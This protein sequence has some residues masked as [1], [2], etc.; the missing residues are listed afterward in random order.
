MRTPA[1]VP[2]STSSVNAVSMSFM[3]YTSFLCCYLSLI[4]AGAFQS[5]SQ[6][7][8]RRGGSCSSPEKQQST[9]SEVQRQI[10]TRSSPAGLRP[11]ATPPS[12][13]PAAAARVSTASLP[14]MD[15]DEGS[16]PTGDVW[17]WRNGWEI[18]YERARSS[19]IR[20][21]NNNRQVDAAGGEGRA[22]G[23]A[24]LLF[25]PG[26]GVGTFHFKRNMQELSKTHDVYA[27]D[28][29]GQG[30]S[31][32][33]RTP[34]RE[35]GLCYSVDMWTEQVR[36]FID[37]VIGEP[38]YVAGNSLGGFIA[39]NLAANH[40]RAVRGLALMNA[41]PFWAFRKPAVAAGVVP[42]ENWAGV[43]DDTSPPSLT[44]GGD[45]GVSGAA[46]PSGVTSSSTK[47]SQPV[48]TSSPAAAAAA[49]AAAEEEEKRVSMEGGGDWLGW[50]G[51][52]PAPAG[53][54]RFG[55]WYFDRMRDPRTVKSM[56][57]AVYS[58]P[59][60]IGDDVVSEIIAATER[61]PSNHEFGVG[62]HEA[63][64]SIVFSPKVSMTFEEMIDR[65]EVPMAL[66]YGKDDPWVVPLW[67]HRIKRQRPET[68]YYEISPSGHSPHHETP[69]TV[70][71]LLAG[72][73]EYASGSGGSPPLSKEGEVLEM[74]EATGARVR[75]TLVPDAKP[76]GPVEW[77]DSAVWSA[78]GGGGSSKTN[79]P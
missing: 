77:L 2:K 75:A 71:A 74:T 39:A 35:D 49:A 69:N 76:R 43:A 30:K 68:L 72:W 73:L 38:A 62:G 63:F 44:G 17:H 22:K 60:A 42:A 1:A 54:F 18:H 47:A 50:D 34:C 58:N 37:E 79:R 11:A 13:D 9:P 20:N 26:F 41:T 14:E 66:M 48:A 78:T 64:T 67:G 46:S 7:L 70:N 21:H 59:D 10:A 56:L 31:W 51:T 29:L 53:L 6:I 36:A 40:P 55:A 45:D 4:C 61:G 8:P 23:V 27:I 19:K 24:P 28:L 5:T 33:T 3:R 52:L 25:L 57:G 12:R 65:V 16:A 32:P 15:E